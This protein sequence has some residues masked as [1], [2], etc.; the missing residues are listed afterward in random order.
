[1]RGKKQVSWGED[2]LNEVVV[3]VPMFVHNK[4]VKKNGGLLSFIN[5]EAPATGEIYQEL[6]QYPGSQGLKGDK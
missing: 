3:D 5:E 6:S 1:M 2:P 4:F